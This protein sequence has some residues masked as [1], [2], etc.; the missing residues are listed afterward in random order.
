MR[1][2]QRRR[3]ERPQAT[4]AESGSA[5]GTQPPGP[6]AP[7]GRDL[8]VAA[9]LAL[10]A[11]LLFTG[12]LRGPFVY[13][14]TR[15][16]AGNL[17][18]QDPAYFGRALMSDVWAFKGSA[19]GAVSHYWR[20]T[21]VLWLIANE[22]AFGLA[23]TT[24]WHAAN[25]LLHGL[26]TGLAFLLARR[27]AVPPVVALAI[28]LLFAIHPAHVESVAWISGAPDPLLAT[29]GLGA[30]LTL[31]SAGL[32]ASP[33]WLG[34]SLL[35]AALATGVKES[36]V[37]LPLVVAALVVALDGA[38]SVG[39]SLRRSWRRAL[40]TALPYAVLAGAYLVARRAVLGPTPPGAPSELDL[41]A[42]LLS[43]P[44]V[45]LFYLRQT[46]WPFSLG[47]SYPLRVVT[48]PG[49]REFWLPLLV[50]VGTVAVLAVAV[51][52]SRVALV[53]AALLVATLL[54]AFN[55]GAFHPEQ[56]VH[57]RYLYLPLLGI[58]LAAVPALARGLAALPG[59]K[60]ARAE[61]VGLALSVALAAL[62]LP[63]TLAYTHA[64]TDEVAL[65]RRGVASD[66]TSAFN[67]NQLAVHLHQ[68]AKAGVGPADRVLL[69]EARSWAD[70]AIALNP[71]EANAYLLRGEIG[72]DEGRFEEAERDLGQAVGQLR[73]TAASYQ[74]FL[75][76]NRLAVAYE[77]AS[78]L[79]AAEALL[80]AARAELPH[81]KC[82]VTHMLAVVL[83]RMGRKGDALAELESVQ[84]DVPQELSAESRMVL[85]R[86]G[87]LYAQQGRRDEA[88]ATLRRYLELSADL[89][90]AQTLS[91]RALATRA[92]ATLGS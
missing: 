90:D 73:G 80:R 86:L 43:A 54:P 76:Y 82:A 72:I 4:A 8:L 78:R 2:Q 9:C 81:M 7:A 57:D 50:V 63:E 35:C 37:L 88:R 10:L 27:L 42:L 55:V 38:P 36:A 3:R 34:L 56:V 67:A 69:A 12:A 58:L 83:Y 40:V 51:R 19:A 31:P 85:F 62:F 14:D 16:I 46:L 17:L 92:L 28:G 68:R 61:G 91:A 48:Q 45:G 59:W 74:L 11:A 84:Q 52:R 71:R 1:R 20:P 18:I 33:A 53:G 87:D 79:G 47:P 13:D 21:F 24:A 25:L 41:D 77:R 26:A 89:Q 64:W 65:W 60:P 32:A 75:A 22:R 44:A 15:Q 29:L 6:D 39:A 23:D 70:R 66:P 30:L 5:A 49:L